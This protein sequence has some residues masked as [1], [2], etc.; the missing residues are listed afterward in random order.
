MAI[1]C[2][3]LEFM[4]SGMLPDCFCLG[5]EMCRE[6]THTVHGITFYRSNKCNQC[7]GIHP[8]PCGC[9]DCPHYAVK[10]GLNVCLIYEFR[11]EYCETCGMNHAHCIGFPDNP[12]VW[13]VRD[14]LCSYDF[15][16]ADGGSM[17]ELPFLNGE[18]WRRDGDHSW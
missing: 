1:T 3:N 18:P 14:G 5:E 12:W 6:T 7:P 2:R 8:P 11:E 16:R 17:D 13:V 10:D 4:Q 15:C 9:G